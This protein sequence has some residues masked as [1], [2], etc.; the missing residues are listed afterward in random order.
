MKTFHPVAFVGM[1]NSDK[2]DSRVLPAEK[3]GKRSW[4]L[5]QLP[6][7]SQS[8]V[9]ETILQIGVSLRLLSK[10]TKIFQ[11]EM[12]VFLEKCKDISYKKLESLFETEF[13]WWENPHYE[14]EWW[15]DIHLIGDKGANYAAMVSKFLSKDLPWDRLISWLRD[16]KNTF[17]N[18]PPIWLSKEW[19]ALIPKRY[20]DDVWSDDEYD[21]LCL[22]LEY[23]EEEFTNSRFQSLLDDQE[24]ND[25]ET[26]EDVHQKNDKEKIPLETGDAEGMIEEKNDD[27][28]RREQQEERNP[29]NDTDEA[30]NNSEN[31]NNSPIEDSTSSEEETAVVVNE[32]IQEEQNELR[33]QVIENIN[34]RRS[35][36]MGSLNAL[37]LIK[38]SDQNDIPEMLK[39]LFERSE[40]MAIDE[41]IEESKKV[42]DNGLFDK[43]LGPNKKVSADDIILVILKAFLRQ[44]NEGKKKDNIS[45]G[46]PRVV[47]AAFFELIDE[48]SDLILAFVFYSEAG[49]VLWAAYAMFVLVGLN[50]VMQ[51]MLMLALGQS[52]LSAIEGLIGIKTITDTYRL[53]AEGPT[54]TRG[55]QNLGVL[56]GYS[57]LLGTIFES[58][59]QMM[60]QV[61][62]VLSS[63]SQKEKNVSTGVV[64]TQ[65]VS[66]AISSA[67]IGLSMASIHMDSALA[68][69]IPGKEVHVSVW[70][71]IPRS[72][73]R[74]TVVLL[75][76]MGGTALHLILAVF[77]FGAL[78]SFAHAGTS[79]SITIGNILIISCLRYW[80]QDVGIYGL[81]MW[82]NQSN[83]ASEPWYEYLLTRKPKNWKE[84]IRDELWDLPYHSS[85]C[86]E[87]PELVGDHDAHC[88]RLVMNY[89][90]IYLP[91]D[92]IEEWLNNKKDKKGCLL[93]IKKVEMED[94][95][96]NGNVRDATED[97]GRVNYKGLY[98]KDDDF[99]DIDV[100][101]AVDGFHEEEE[102]I[103]KN[104]PHEEL[105]WLIEQESQGHSGSDVNNSVVKPMDLQSAIENDLVEALERTDFTV[106]L[107]RIIHHHQV[108][109]EQE[110]LNRKTGHDHN[111]SS[112][113]LKTYPS[114]RSKKKFIKGKFIKKVPLTSAKTSSSR[115]SWTHGNPDQEED[116][117]QDEVEVEHNDSEAR[118]Q[119]YTSNDNKEMLI[120][121]QCS[122]SHHVIE[123]KK[124]RKKKVRI[125]HSYQFPNSDNM[126]GSILPPQYRK[127]LNNMKTNAMASTLNATLKSN[128]STNVKSATLTS[129]PKTTV[130]ETSKNKRTVPKKSKRIAPFFDPE[131]DTL[132]Q[133]WIDYMQA[134]DSS[135]KKKAQII[136]KAS[137]PI[138]TTSQPIDTTSPSI[139]MTSNSSNDNVMVSMSNQTQYQQGKEHKDVRDKAQM[140]KSKKIKKKSNMLLKL[141]CPC[142]FTFVTLQ[143]KSLQQTQ[144]NSHFGRVKNVQRRKR[145]AAGSTVM[146]VSPTAVNVNLQR[147]TIQEDIDRGMTN[148]SSG[149]PQQLGVHCD[150]CGTCI[151]Y[152]DSVKDNEGAEA[153]AYA[154][155]INKTLER[156]SLSK[157]DITDE[158][159]E[160]MA[161]ALKVNE[162]LDHL[163]FY[164]N[165][166]EDQG[167][168]AIADALKVNKTLVSLD[169]QGNGITDEGAEA[170]ATALKV[171]KTLKYLHLC[172]NKF[173]V[174]GLEAIADALE[175]NKTLWCDIK[176]QGPYIP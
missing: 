66:V 89:R 102:Y 33:Q 160:A 19:L 147:S 127:T 123:G 50:R 143:A 141:Q 15:N 85:G 55:G 8:N 150:V 21:E 11:G 26:L 84:C 172:E 12:E 167:A 166:I 51:F 30:A 5:R 42:L 108:D 87:I 34:E 110:T 133:Q 173:G 48:I 124:K 140:R 58:F 101:D 156:L 109:R 130:L 54:G 25:H 52:L 60:L 169:L 1:V 120:S 27:I 9:N 2:M 49:D 146:Y 125:I 31:P 20:R 28:S 59:P 32:V 68:C 158:G 159:A 57:L 56:R 119:N 24:V 29:T 41:I 103:Q 94:F 155:K 115:L 7:R 10:A 106:G 98:E 90:D 69:T 61:V 88:A 18:R 148:G 73:S 86:W 37:Q 36:F 112:K 114:G 3:S 175:V 117:G 97:P 116:E 138:D 22:R 45:E 4:S 131:S 35:S 14:S 63:F 165:R 100:L 122:S 39:D 171:N 113:S 99:Y 13:N 79:I 105:R 153:I 139:D 137:Q 95:M 149:V 65:L 82:N 38:D 154:L 162:T 126:E 92:K 136:D 80:A 176:Y 70:K 144:F 72:G 46:L 121:E 164:S 142:C 145:G 74:Q 118:Q 71:H 47:M 93:E 135:V 111:K 161:D 62:I 40:I 107:D 104:N 163:N 91:F 78:F 23:V 151:G 67:S 129:F 83:G 17:K 168:V 64:I 174:R 6:T 170:I 53:I 152:K 77:G 44:R 134:R 43:L 16:N 157:N 132:N 76:L 128:Q 96:V 75:S 81:D